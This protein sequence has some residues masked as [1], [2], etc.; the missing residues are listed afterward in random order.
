MA[1]HVRQFDRYQTIYNWEHYIPLLERKPG[2]LRNGAPFM[3]MPE[4]LLALQR[5]LLRHPGGD[6]VMAQVLSAIPV[7][8]IEEVLVAVEIALESGRPSGE[9]VLNVLGR[10]KNPSTPEAILVTSLNVRVEPAANVSRYET[11]RNI[12]TETH[13]VP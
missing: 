1:R 12:A 11:L 4:P 2:A 6:R 8:G 3:E 10:L 9:H 13:H 7:H 5:H